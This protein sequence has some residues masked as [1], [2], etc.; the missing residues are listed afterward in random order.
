MYEQDLELEQ[1]STRLVKSSQD[2]ELDTELSGVDSERLQRDGYERVDPT[3]DGL[4]AIPEKEIG[5][6]SLE[7]QDYVQL[8]RRKVE[9]LMGLW[10]DVLQQSLKIGSQP[11]HLLPIHS[12]PSFKTFR[13]TPSSFHGR[14]PPILRFKNEQPWT[15]VD[16]M[17]NAEIKAEDGYRKLGRSEWRPSDEL[18]YLEDSWK[19][20]WEPSAGVDRG[21]FQW[22]CSEET[23][24]RLQLDLA[25]ALNA[26]NR[27]VAFN[28]NMRQLGRDY[29]EISTLI[30]LIGLR[31]NEQYRSY[32]SIPEIGPVKQI[33]ILIECI[34]A[35]NAFDPSTTRA[36]G[37][38]EGPRLSNVLSACYRRG[39]LSR[40]EPG[41]DE[42]VMT[43]YLQKQCQNV[44]RALHLINLLSKHH[45]SIYLPL[46]DLKDAQEAW[47][48]PLPDAETAPTTPI[49]RQRPSEPREGPDVFLRIDDFN[50]RDLQ[51]L[52]HLQIQWTSYWDEHLQL[53]TSS[54]TNVLKIFWFQPKLG[55]YI[56]ENH[57]TGY[58]PSDSLTLREDELYRTWCLIFTSKTTPRASLT[59]YLSLKSPLWLSL[60]AHTS[61]NTWT[62]EQATHNTYPSPTPPLSNLLP[63]KNLKRFSDEPSDHLL[64]Q[65]SKD[66]SKK[67]PHER[68]S[69][70][71]FPVYGDRLRELRVYMDSQQ[72]TGLR[73]LWKDRRNSNTYYTFW[74]VTIFGS[75]SVFLAAGALAVGIAQTWAAFRQVGG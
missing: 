20:I 54:T 15:V 1:L 4:P 32:H 14:Y 17:S 48:M 42:H 38:R 52:G 34:W 12:E 29:R 40:P 5:D 36:E 45:I 75:L 55:R 19:H 58:I 69:Y 30:S 44:R 13:S 25:D 62:A 7:G 9:Q 26:N 61:L 53:E 50:L 51:I 71:Q 11:T 49:I 39:I 16:R 18:A 47:D 60:L 67:L 64:L 43:H 68:I 63:P 24:K 72:P 27:I 33:Q 31:L 6:A 57:L 74:F 41:F 66:G 2:S 22:P 23:R 56:V 35:C 37:Y 73:A 65:W 3:K 8:P 21:L 28:T 10:I 59:R 70:S 46:G